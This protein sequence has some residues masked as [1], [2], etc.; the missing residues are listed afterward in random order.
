MSRLLLLA[1]LVGCSPASPPESTPVPTAAPTPSAEA[2]AGSSS[3][4]PAEPAAAADPPCP[5]EREVTPGPAFDSKSLASAGAIDGVAVG[6]P[7]VFEGTVYGSGR[8]ALGA[9]TRV[10]VPDTAIVREGAA[11][12]TV[13]VFVAR[14]LR[15]KGHPPREMPLGGVRQNMGL[16]QRV[17][18][19]ELRLSTF[20]EF[21][22]KEGGATVQLA[23]LVPPGVP[24]VRRSGLTGAESEA[25]NWHTFKASP[26]LGQIGHWYS[27]PNAN[28]LYTRV[29]LQDDAKRV[30][31]HMGGAP[32]PL[33]C[34]PARAQEP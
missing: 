29:A 27:T 26:S 24:V 13:F 17:E 33:R 23:V 25:A 7:P 31:S 10:V 3:P 19:N 1:L 20:G 28:P 15:F 16:A 21:S 22:S 11:G 30:V 18:A 9:A 6:E 2:P 8:V 14:S 34:E 12:K 32:S 5:A 4:A